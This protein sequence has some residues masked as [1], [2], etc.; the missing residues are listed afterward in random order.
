MKRYAPW[1]I[2]GRKVPLF[3]LG[4]SLSLLFVAGHDGPTSAGLS[5]PQPSG[6]LRALLVGGG[7]TPENNQVSIESNVRYVFRLLPPGSECSVLFADGDRK[8]ET[9]LYEQTTEKLPANERLLAL[10]L[11]GPEAANSVQRKYRTPSLPQLDGAARKKDVAAAFERLQI[12]PRTG[13]IL[14]YFTGHGSRAKDGNLDN[15]LYDLWGESLSVREL[16]RH[17]ADL[18]CACP[19]T[20]VMVQCYSGAF[21]NLLFEEGNPQGAPVERDIVGFFATIKERPAAGC[22]P[23]LNEREYHD[24]TSYFFAA[25]TGRD[26]VGRK[27]TGADYNRDGRVGMDE[28]FCYTLIHDPSIDIPV[29]TSDIYLRREI[30]VPDSLLFQTPYRQVRA[31]ATPAQR[32]ALEAISSKLGLTGDDR[33]R[34]AYEQFLESPRPFSLRRDPRSM[35]QRSFFQALR[36]ARADLV[37][38]WP[39]LEDKMSPSWA[40]AKAE[41]LKYLATPDAQQE[42]RA[43]IEA[44]RALRAAEKANQEK[45]L[46]ES[47]QARFVRLYKSVVLA[48]MLREQGTP[49]QKR[50]FARL[51]LAE[52][53]TIFTPISGLRTT[54]GL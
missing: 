18:P 20:L 51:A 31:W 41:A 21:G 45:Q 22:T 29:C 36:E 32:A 39:A 50:R 49:L 53:R 2:P 34:V 6:K 40:A 11:E 43:L 8:N 16:A 26:R 30:A 12:D 10:I 46:A 52:S 17:I 4:V 27:V 38:R 24:F 47:W 13:P 48:H 19:I 54:S 44:E 42:Y 35:A 33:G 14:L 9:V 28:A 5:F 37:A 1:S 25:L 3:A 23:E 15:N 7:P